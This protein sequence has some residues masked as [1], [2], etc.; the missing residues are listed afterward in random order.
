LLGGGLQTLRHYGSNLLTM[1]TGEKL[2]RVDDAILQALATRQC[3]LIRALANRGH[4]AQQ[5]L[6]SSQLSGEGKILFN[7][8]NLPA[9]LRQARANPDWASADRMR[10]LDNGRQQAFNELAT[11]LAGQIAQDEEKNGSG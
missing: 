10:L 4:A 1:V 9:P 3:L 6:A 7:D 11:I 2:L 8:N 5:K